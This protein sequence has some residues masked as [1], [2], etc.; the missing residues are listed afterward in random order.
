MAK[1][2]EGICTFL[3]V[4]FGSAVL[5]SMIGYYLVWLGVSYNVC[6]ENGYCGGLVVILALS[7]LFLLGSYVAIRVATAE[8]AKT[9]DSDG[10]RS[11]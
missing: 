9:P 2:W 11:T 8:D 6:G 7:S 10:T 3:A 5:I 4:G 1:V